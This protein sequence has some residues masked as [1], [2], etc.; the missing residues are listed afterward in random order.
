MHSRTASWK[1]LLFYFDPA[2]ACWRA[3]SASTGYCTNRAKTGAAPKPFVGRV[4]AQSRKAETALYP[5]ALDTA[6][7]GATGSKGGGIL[8]RFTQQHIFSHTG[9]QAQQHSNNEERKFL[10]DG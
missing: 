9:K 1:M 8:V 3:L 4:A 5:G 10:S 7:L 2:I 6:C